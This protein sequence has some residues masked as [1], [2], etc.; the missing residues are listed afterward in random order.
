MQVH[1]SIPFIFTHH[2]SICFFPVKFSFEVLTI[3]RSNLSSAGAQG[4][5]T[6][7]FTTALWIN[8]AVFGIELVGFTLLRTNFKAIY[9]PR[10]YLPVEK[11]V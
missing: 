5:T 2:V 6:K 7:T 10:T 11:C 9:E 8:A 1:F 4:A 3:C